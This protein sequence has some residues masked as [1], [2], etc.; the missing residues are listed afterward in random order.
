MNFLMSE[1]MD[2]P[3]D[4]LGL[5]GSLP[6][7]ALKLTDHIA[8]YTKTD[9]SYQSDVLNAMRGLFSSFA[10]ATPPIL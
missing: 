1:E 9:L 10:K 6:P 8:Q 7:F 5:R 2:Y 4:N 3:S